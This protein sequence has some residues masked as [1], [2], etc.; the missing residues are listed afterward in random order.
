[1]KKAHKFL[2]I[3]CK[4]DNVL[5]AQETELLYLYGAINRSGTKEL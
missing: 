4:S 2:D 3:S 1:M 5:A